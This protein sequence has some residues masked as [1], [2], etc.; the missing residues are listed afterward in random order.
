MDLEFH[1]LDM[2][3]EERFA[4]MSSFTNFFQIIAENV[5]D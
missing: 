4:W 5:T 2:S 1:F 3:E